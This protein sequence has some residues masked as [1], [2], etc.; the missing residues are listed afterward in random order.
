MVLKKLF[1]IKN[2]IVVQLK[3]EIAVRFLCFI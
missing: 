3:T 2:L 1:I